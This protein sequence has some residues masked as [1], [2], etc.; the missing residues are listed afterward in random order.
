MVPEN[1]KEMTLVSNLQGVVVS[2][3]AVTQH[4]VF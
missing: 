3:I 1:R 2:E 4:T